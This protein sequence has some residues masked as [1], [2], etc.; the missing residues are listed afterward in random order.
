MKRILALFVL[1]IMFMLSI[2]TA[3]ADV[4][5]DGVPYRTDVVTVP[6]DPVNDG[7]ITDVEVLASTPRRTVTRTVTTSNSWAS[8]PA[9]TASACST[10]QA[11][12]CSSSRSVTRTRT[13][14]LF[15]A[16]LR[17]GC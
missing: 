15:G 1:M 8:A 17:G 14:R 4:F 11:S 12:A 10:V 16:R 2:P 13:F 5:V 9:A 3:R 7:T 6:A